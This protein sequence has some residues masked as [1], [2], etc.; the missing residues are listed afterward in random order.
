MY[1]YETIVG[2]MP[3]S[4]I[5]IYDEANGRGEEYEFSSQL[6]E[7]LEYGAKVLWETYK[8]FVIHDMVFAS[9]VI[10]VSEFED[11]EG[12]PIMNFDQDS[13]GFPNKERKRAVEL[14]KNRKYRLVH[15]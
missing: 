13:T 14:Y 6:N 7:V 11:G 15:G 9:V 8:V 10:D 4:E 3:G 1:V 12:V 5:N 2:Y